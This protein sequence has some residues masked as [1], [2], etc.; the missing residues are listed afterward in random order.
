MD[1]H[2][3]P[4]RNKRQHRRKPHTRPLQ[5]TPPLFPSSFI[6]VFQLFCVMSVVS[7][8]SVHSPL[9]MVVFSHRTAKLAVLRLAACC[10]SVRR[11]LVG[12]VLRTVLTKPSAVGRR[13]LALYDGVKLPA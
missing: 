1:S 5:P 3:R 8:L 9:W 11:S 2:M 13:S 4:P 6:S 7:S 12:S 10:M